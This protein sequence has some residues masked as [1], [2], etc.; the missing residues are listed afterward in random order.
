[1][2]SSYQHQTHSN[3]NH[4]TTAQA[5]TPSVQQPT[6][7]MHPVSPT[8]E[9][10][11]DDTPDFVKN[12]KI[13]LLLELSN[14]ILAN[15][16]LSLDPTSAVCLALT[17]KC[18]KAIVIKC[19]KRSLSEI[20]SKLIARDENKA[21]LTSKSRLPSVE[22]IMTAAEAD[23]A[24]DY[25][26]RILFHCDVKIDGRFRLP[27]DYMCL[28]ES[29]RGSCWMPRMPGQVYCED[30]GHRR[31][32]YQAMPAKARSLMA[33]FGGCFICRLMD[34]FDRLKELNKTFDK[35]KEG[36]AAEEMA[37]ASE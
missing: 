24:F 17:S 22:A 23:E 5:D 8:S 19:Y 20:C 36:E 2:S 13:A 27:W 25:V 1:M 32:A 11:E 12:P 21:P 28:V 26:W 30:R 15:I 6:T 18:L 31:C 16:T 29:L 34:S 14:E 33:L 4:Q 9:A 37:R 35:I 3:R 7:T 10:G